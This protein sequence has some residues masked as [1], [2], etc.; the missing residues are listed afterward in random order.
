MKY[1]NLKIGKQIFFGFLIVLIL[2]T[3]IGF[4]GWERVRHISNRAEQVQS[5]D[6]A[7]IHALE[8]Q[9]YQKSYYYEMKPMDSLYSINSAK[10]VEKFIN[11]AYDRKAIS[12]FKRD[13]MLEFISNFSIDYLH[14]KNTLVDLRDSQLKLNQLASNINLNFKRDTNYY[15]RIIS[16]TIQLFNEVNR[17]DNSFFLLNRDSSFLVSRNQKIVQVYTLA[18]QSKNADLQNQLIKYNKLFL[19]CLDFL[20]RNNNYLIEIDKWGWTTRFHS[21]TKKIELHLKQKREVEQTQI[22]IIF[23]SIL[24]T[25]LA[26]FIGYRISKGVSGGVKS[27]THITQMVSDGDLTMSIEPQLLKKKNEIGI[28]SRSLFKMT[29]NL[30]LIA[31][32]VKAKAKILSVSGAELSS[33]SQSLSSNSNQQAASLEEISSAVQQMTANIHHNAESAK[34]TE[35]ITSIAVKEIEKVRESALQ[36]TASITVIAEKIKIINEI[37]FQTNLLALNAAIEAARAGHYGKGFSVVAGEVKKLAERSRAAAD[38]IGKISKI[39]VA[40]SVRSSDMLSNII[41]NIQKSALLIENISAS[42]RELNSGAEQINEAI[43]QLN[44]NT[45]QTAAAS[46]ELAVNAVD[47]VTKARELEELVAFFKTDED[48]LI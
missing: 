22:V 6:Y 7:T 28:L 48:M 42:G 1:S 46:E 45:Q 11:E 32:H 3:L 41:P 12:E 31:A 33:A 44:N 13:T 40:A 9:M 30:K 17:L 15:G 34:E 20:H 27:S 35:S 5:L 29:D 38:E 36:S 39:S 16:Q 14:Y 26:F 23:L 43:Q 19:T 21:F 4:I 2:T 8:A 47:L 24:V 10:T 18:N 25:V 37:A